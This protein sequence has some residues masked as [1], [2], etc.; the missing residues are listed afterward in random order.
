M[1]D[2][3]LNYLNPVKAKG[4]VYWYYRRD[5]MRQRIAG[6]PG[7]PEFLEN[8]NRIHAAF[9]AEPRTGAAPGTFASLITWYL[10][11]PEYMELGDR[12]KQEYRAYLDQ[13]RERFGHL[14]YRSM[15]RRFVMGYRDS[16]A[17]T[18]S[19]ANHAV[20]VLRRLLSYALDLELIKINPAAGVKELRTG[21]GWQSWPEPALE[22]FHE[23]ARGAAR[24][25]FMLALYTGQR[26]G[27]VLAMRWS[28]I[29]G[30]GFIRVTQAKTGTEL[31]IP[32]HPTLA[33]E[34]AGVEKRDLAIVG[35]SDG[36]P[37]TDSGFNAIW[38][39]EKARLGLGGVVFH[40]L[41][42]NAVAA[43]Y[44]AQCTP[45]QVQAITGHASLE[46]VAHYGKGA[47]QKVLATQAMNR[48]TTASGKPGDK[49][50]NGSAGRDQ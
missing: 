18:P 11:S 10:S 20:K 34:L 33:G 5:G 19:K 25:A 46:M 21:D 43:L 47:R 1:T 29:T 40:G 15:S 7:T 22:R 38:R 16:M 6:K 12:A 32:I 49:P 2:I 8:Y 42:K 48:L 50:A 14:S 45:Q 26:K 41:R 13:M 39:R 31:F 24:V 28:D 27:D 23:E 3:P 4:R 9:E 30:D 44:E 37:Y 17:A 36:K 35:R